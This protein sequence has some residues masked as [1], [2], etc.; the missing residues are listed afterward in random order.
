[1]GVN[2][3]DE[4]IKY[5]TNTRFPFS[6]ARKRMSVIVEINGDKYLFTKGASEIVLKGCNYW[7]NSDKNET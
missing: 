3:E 4:R 5:P 1:M 7:L 6:S 2:Y